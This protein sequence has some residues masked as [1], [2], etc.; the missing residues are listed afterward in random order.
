MTRADLMMPF[1]YS[2]E[3]PLSRNDSLHEISPAGTIQPW[4]TSVD[5]MTRHILVWG[6]DRTAAPDAFAPVL[7]K[8]VSGMSAM[9]LIFWRMN[10]YNSAAAGRLGSQNWTVH[11]TEEVGFASR[12]ATHA[13]VSQG[14]P[15]GLMPIGSRALL[16]VGAEYVPDGM[17]GFPRLFQVAS[18]RRNS[19]FSAALF[20]HAR[21]LNLTIAFMLQDTA[22]NEAIVIV[23]PFP[24][25]PTG[26]L[27]LGSVRSVYRSSNVEEALQHPYRFADDVETN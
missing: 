7:H 21:Q 6:G 4:S 1:V 11:L 23:T 14:S 16:I 25:D 12:K 13:E 3:Q 26:C 19:A 24:F 8:L 20:A 9:W 10:V 5:G 27:P 2:V 17:Y 18:D 15:R 22:G